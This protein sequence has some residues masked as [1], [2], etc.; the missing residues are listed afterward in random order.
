MAERSQFLVT[1]LL[2][3]ALTA[4]AISRHRNTK[5]YPDIPP[6][7]QTHSPLFLYVPASLAFYDSQGLLFTPRES[8]LS[9]LLVYSHECPNQ[10]VVVSLG[11]VQ[12]CHFTWWKHSISGGHDFKCNSPESCGNR[13]TKSPIEFLMIGVNLLLDFWSICSCYWDTVPYNYCWFKVYILQESTQ[14]HG[15][16][17][18]VPWLSLS[19][20]IPISCKAD[21]FW[22]NTVIDTING[23]HQQT[24]FSVKWFFWSKV[25]VCEIPR[26]EMSLKSLLLTTLEQVVQKG[27]AN[28]RESKDKIFPPAGC[29]ASHGID[30]ALQFIV[31]NF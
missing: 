18:L 30:L 19:E 17:Q 3:Q 1:L 28:P 14:T 23:S 22:G 10:A 5:K 25:M 20:D 21:N 11:Y 16:F 9:L 15:M 24:S 8:M 6:E 7:F 13:C 31:F 29:K 4:S 2:C 26:W 12:P 27:K